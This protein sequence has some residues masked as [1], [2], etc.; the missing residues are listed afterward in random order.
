MHPTLGNFPTLE[1]REA[2]MCRVFATTL[3]AGELR[4]D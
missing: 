2:E 4:F 3:I 1:G